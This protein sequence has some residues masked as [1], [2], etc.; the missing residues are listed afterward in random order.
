MK[1][2]SS[3]NSNGLSSYG[4]YQSLV[5]TRSILEYDVVLSARNLVRA[6]ASGIFRGSAETSMSKAHRI[7][8]ARSSYSRP[9]AID[10]TN[11]SLISSNVRRF[12][13]VFHIS[14][15]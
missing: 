3:K 7:V 5:T 14:S 6:W 2:V 12:T 13:P 1:K 15:V 11:L 4:G 9:N 8:S 10:V